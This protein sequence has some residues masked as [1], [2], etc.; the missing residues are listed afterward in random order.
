MCNHREKKKI[1]KKVRIVFEK[2][3]VLHSMIKLNA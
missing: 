2:P 1:G 3:V